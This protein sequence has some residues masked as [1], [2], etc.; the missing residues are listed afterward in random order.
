ML[1][2]HVTVGLLNGLCWLN[3]LLP[4]GANPFTRST[5]LTRVSSTKSRLMSVGN[6]LNGMVTVVSG[7]PKSKSAL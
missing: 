3:A 5:T 7:V 6:E 4:G 1:I 2:V